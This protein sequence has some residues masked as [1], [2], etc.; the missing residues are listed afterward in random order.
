[1]TGP[2]AIH[3][4]ILTKPGKKSFAKRTN[5]KQL[6]L[7]GFSRTTYIMKRAT[8]RGGHVWEQSLLATRALAS[9]IM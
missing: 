7:L 5:M 9:L 6:R 2:V 1:M 4:E 3:V 8:C